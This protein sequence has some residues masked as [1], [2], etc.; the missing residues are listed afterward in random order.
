MKQVFIAEVV[1]DEAGRL[2]VVPSEHS[3]VM[4]YREGVEVHWDP[5]RRSL[6]SPPPR[7]WSY[8]QWFAHIHAAAHA[9]GCDLQLG[10]DT[11]WLNIAPSLQAEIRQLASTRPG[12]CNSIS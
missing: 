8:L 10:A 9:H 6:H 5:D 1:I 4:I 7:Q 2:H 12:R 3:F 11:H